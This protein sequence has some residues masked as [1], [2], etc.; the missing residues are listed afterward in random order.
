[1]KKRYEIGDKVKLSPESQYYGQSDGEDGEIKDFEHKLPDNDSQINDFKYYYH[2]R[3]KNGHDYVYRYTD[4]MPAEKIIKEEKTLK[5][6]AIERFGFISKDDKFTIINKN[7]DGIIKEENPANWTED[8]DALWM[9]K[10]GEGG[11]CIYFKGE[12]AER[13]SLPK[14]WAVK[15]T[16]NPEYQPELL[17]WRGRWTSQGW[18]TDS[19]M[20]I[21]YI[22]KDKGIITYEQFLKWVYN[23]WKKQIDD[24][25]EPG[26]WVIGWYYSECELYHTPWK[27]KKLENR[28]KIYAVPEG[29][30]GWC[31]NISHL[32]K[33]F[34]PQQSSM[35]KEWTPKFKIGDRVKVVDETDGW[36]EVEYGDIGVVVHVP[37]NK[38]SVYRVNFDKES[39][40]NGAEECFILEESAPKFKV[41]DRVRA[42]NQSHGWGFVDKG[43]IGTVISIRKSLHW[44]GEDIYFV[45]FGELKATNW[46]AHESCLE[47][48]EE[49]MQGEF[50]YSPLKL[51]SIG[52]ML[53][54]NDSG[55]KL[56]LGDTPLVRVITTNG[57]SSEFKNEQSINLLIHKPKK[58]K[59]LK[60]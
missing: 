14:N 30:P 12:W 9:A 47:L 37:K 11:L 53:N 26:D 4:L 21:T 41:G 34:A 5:Q 33:L 28:S 44:E 16:L 36:G 59:Q 17:E 52:Q 25:I 50:V 31:C 13:T 51:S 45:D 43:D 60:L 39:G 40:W 3:W 2:V 19:G 15:T 8:S 29:Y 56:Q 38:N 18:V 1:M 55:Y 7:C 42:I 58:V 35:E 46:K 22:L 32:R 48:V 49:S 20:W 54:P 23:P 57:I 6:Q 24:S 10:G 27:V